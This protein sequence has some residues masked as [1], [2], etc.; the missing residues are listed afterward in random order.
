MNQTPIN[1]DEHNLYSELEHNV[2]K[3]YKKIVASRYFTSSQLEEVSMEASKR[4]ND[5]PNLDPLYFYLTYMKGV[6][7]LSLSC[8]TYEEYERRFRHF[9]TSIADEIINLLSKVERVTY[10]AFL[11]QILFHFVYDMNESRAPWSMV[12]KRM[13][14][15]MPIEHLEP[16]Y[17]FLQ[18]SLSN[19]EASRD[20]SLTYSYI[21]LLVGKEKEALKLLELSILPVTEQEVTLHFQC[22]KKHERWESMR[23]WFSTL[24]LQRPNGPYGS[25]QPLADE[26]KASLHKD[27]RELTHVW[28]RWL[29]APS[30]HRFQSLTRHLSIE[31]KDLLL[32]DLLPKMQDRFHQVETITTYMKLLLEYKRFDDASRYFLLHERDPLRL[33]PEKIKLLEALY[34]NRPLLI[35]PI[36]HQFVVRLVEKKSRAH[37]E[38]AVIFIKM[39]SKLYAS[40]NESVRFLDYVKRMK[41]T[42]RTYRAFVEELKTIES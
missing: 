6:S 25:L 42:Y 27:P 23:H 2:I 17:Y 41:K 20:V 31:E 30:Y 14:T 24:F 37:Y 16:T 22:L 9:F 5:H 1:F 36:Y 34:E 21:A 11:E 33:R 15:R 35:K 12:L 8:S 3:T 29:L 10:R 13:L 38:Q 40:S 32:E 4:L 28:N 18:D 26:M 7:F 19:Q 39:L